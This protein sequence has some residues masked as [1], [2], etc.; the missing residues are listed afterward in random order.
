MT[1]AE[2]EE[3]DAQADYQVM[4]ED[5]ADKRATDAKSL[6]EKESAKASMEEEQENH[7]GGTTSEEKQLGATKK[8]IIQTHS[9][10]DWLMQYY[11]VRKSARASE[12][13]ALNNA[14]S[15]LNGADY[16]L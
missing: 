6:Q 14:Q 15:V 9:E 5:A 1:E 11:D 2:T 12:L 7:K 4:M 3:K 13:D 8:Y 10:C 16:S